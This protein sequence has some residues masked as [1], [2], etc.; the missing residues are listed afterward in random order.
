MT[1]TTVDIETIAEAGVV[2]A[3]V[4]AFPTHVKLSGK[5]DA[6]LINAAECEP[7]LH[8]DKELLHSYGDDVLEGLQ[9]AMRR[10]HRPRA[11]SA[12]RRSTT[13]SSTP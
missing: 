13:T 12:S 9:E 7:L 10:G 3:G 1:T 11:G 4:Q 6:V 2:G 8:K 5:A